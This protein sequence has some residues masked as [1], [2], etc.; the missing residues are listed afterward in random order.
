MHLA[1]TSVVVVGVLSRRLR[2][3]SGS[4]V[5]G[6]VGLVLDPDLLAELAV[7][8]SVALVSGT[9]GKTTTTRLLAEACGG[10]A[11]VATSLA[12]ANMPAGLVAALASAP[13][14]RSPAVLE[15][16]EAYLGTVDAAVGAR[17]VVA[18]NLSRDQLDRVGEVRSVAARWRDGFAAT[19]ATVVANCDDPLVVWAASTARQVLWVAA[20]GTW[21][22]DSHHCPA[23]GA[24]IDFSPTAGPIGSAVDPSR[25][26][27][28]WSCTCGLERPAPDAWLLDDALVVGDRSWPFA[29]ALPGR[30]NASNAAMA[31][32]AASVLG[33]DVGEALAA[34]S[35]VADV[36]GRF[37]HKV[38]RGVAT[39]LLLAKNPAGWTELVAL[40]AEGRAPAVV[41]VNARSADGHDPSW[42]WDV[43]FERIA[44]RHVVVTGERRF[45]LAV[46]LRHAGVAHTTV[47]DQLLAIEVASTGDP[48]ETVDYV[49][50]YTAFQEVRRAVTGLPAPPRGKSGEG[51]HAT[52][53]PAPGSGAR[54]VERQG[55]ARRDPL[56]IVVV[57]PD[58]LG[59]Y[60]DAGNALVLANRARWRDMPAELLLVRS[61]EPLPRAADLY[62]LGGGED[63]PQSLSADKLADGS[64]AGALTRGATVLA[65]CAGFQILGS[66]FPGPHGA[67]HAGLGLLD[68][69]TVRGVGKRAVGEVLAEVVPDTAPVDHG[70]T[71]GAA[72]GSLAGVERLTGFANHGGATLLGPVLAPLARVLVGPGNDGSDDGAVDGG[73]EGKVV[74]T[75]LH[76]PVLARNPTLADALL[77]LATG[78]TLDP[79]DDAEEQALRSDRLRSTAGSR[80]GKIRSGLAR[81]RRIG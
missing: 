33:A 43:P 35:R 31:A 63:G 53:G 20:G 52:P 1:R 27:T 24:H 54:E 75:Y 38:V 69:T 26:G 46:R 36:A 13:G 17:V 37:A 81:A 48:E 59:T 60:G 51:A 12:G 15:V 78:A 73:R 71:T 16:D 47:A 70:A 5:G 42:L 14:P 41:A 9:N 66:T 55:R 80:A 29:L 74:A 49:G 77:R 10:P 58:L 44:H 62:C 64:L 19:A 6:R 56:R 45:D 25:A 22:D 30:F 79:L 28:G 39:R 61:D 2:V 50:N 67:P 18:L 3:G 4:T 65:V 68:V 34:M 21:R 23:C 32:V 11:G 57:H 72:R 76:G 8:R 40:L 7:G